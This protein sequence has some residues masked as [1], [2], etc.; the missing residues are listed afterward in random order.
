[1]YMNSIHEV[2]TFS[3]PSLLGWSKIA[4]KSKKSAKTLGYD[5]FEKPTKR[6]KM[7]MLKTY[8]RIL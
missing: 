7:M 2:A 4:F 1:M 5:S 6:A 3:F 8:L